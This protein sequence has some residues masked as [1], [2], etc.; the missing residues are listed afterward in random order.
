MRVWTLSEKIEI[1]LDGATPV[2][3]SGRGRYQKGDAIL[4]DLL[5]IDYKEYKKSFGLS[6]S[7]WAKLCTDNLRNRTVAG[8]F[9]VILGEGNQKVRLWVLDDTL[10]K[11]MYAAWKREQNEVPPV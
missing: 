8:V 4:D 5:T 7:T 10:F 9:K 6:L 1:Q 3:N 2:K 11:E